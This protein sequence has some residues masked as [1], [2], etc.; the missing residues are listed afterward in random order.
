MP[1][2]ILPAD[3]AILVNQV[4]VKPGYYVHLVKDARVEPA[5]STDKNCYCIAY[6]LDVE[7]KGL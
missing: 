2:D 7:A 4:L 6:A 3:R 1:I 5:S